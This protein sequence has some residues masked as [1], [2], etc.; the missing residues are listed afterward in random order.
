MKFAQVLAEHIKAS[1]TRVVMGD[2]NMALPGIATMMKE[3]Y[4]INLEI[5]SYYPRL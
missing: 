2:A 3:W 1:K 5:V 4:N